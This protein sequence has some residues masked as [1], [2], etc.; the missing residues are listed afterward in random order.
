METVE[1]IQQMKDNPKVSGCFFW[2]YQK[3]EKFIHKQIRIE[4]IAE[5]LSNEECEEYHNK[6][7]L[8]CQIRSH[9]CQQ[10]QK[11]DWDELKK[12]HD[13]ILE[14]VKET[15]K[16]LKMPEYYVAYRIIPNMFDF[17]YSYNTNIADRLAFTKQC[18]DKWTFERIAA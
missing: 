14:A 10:G 8:F 16:P 7:P 6:D 13:E 11:V 12:K 3:D 15:N 18:E 2:G 4:G 1:K 5:K 9:I 17:Y